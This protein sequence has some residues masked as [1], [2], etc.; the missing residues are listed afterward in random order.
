MPPVAE[1]GGG[2]GW[3]CGAR[4]RHHHRERLRNL[5]FFEHS[6]TAACG[7]ASS[8][9]AS[10]RRQRQQ[11]ARRAR[12]AEGVLPRRQR[13]SLRAGARRAPFVLCRV[14]RAHQDGRVRR[15]VQLPC[16]TTTT[17]AAARAPHKR[18]PAASK[19]ARGA[20]AH[21]RQGAPPAAQGPGLAHS[22]TCAASRTPCVKR[23]DNGDRQ[24]PTLRTP[25][26]ARARGARRFLT[27]NQAESCDGSSRTA[28]PKRLARRSY[29]MMTTEA[30]RASQTTMAEASWRG[31]TLDGSPYD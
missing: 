14:P 26:A 24:R 23:V 28:A 13:S 25:T 30:V 18:Q 12:R 10:R 27:E 17:T 9:R 5:E 21:H 7:V 29:V 22:S 16:V 19:R 20:C 31:R 11:L 4:A 1:T 8:C 15:D 6:S 2:G 3:T